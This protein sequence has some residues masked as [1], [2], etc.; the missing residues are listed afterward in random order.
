MDM[1]IVLRIGAG[2]VVA[3]LGLVL[4]SRT[5]FDLRLTHQQL[6][7]VLILGGVFFTYRA[8]KAYFDAR[9]HERHHD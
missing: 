9:D 8:V 5:T 6:G 1:G 7:I 3:L 2:A 4:A